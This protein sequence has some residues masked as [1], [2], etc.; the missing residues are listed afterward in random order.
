MNREPMIAGTP[1]PQP[2]DPVP[3]PDSAVVVD[4]LRLK[5]YRGD[6]SSE[7]S[8]R[9][10]K[11]HSG[12]IQWDEKRGELVTEL[13]SGHTVRGPEG[14]A[15]L[16]HELVQEHK[17]LLRGPP[18]AGLLRAELQNLGIPDEVIAAN[19]DRVRRVLDREPEAGDVLYR[20]I[21][22]GGARYGQAAEMVKMAT[23]EI[24]SRYA[25]QRRSEPD[26]V[27]LAEVRARFGDSI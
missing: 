7:E 27:V 3:P 1:L 17:R 21:G 13:L 10:A 20:P 4:D 8:A 26:P 22:G 5:L 16:A 2:R 14:V 6:F 15:G 12:R 24:A 25:E 23:L 19:E 18:P 11:A 9:L